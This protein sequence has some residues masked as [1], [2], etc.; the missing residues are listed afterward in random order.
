MKVFKVFFK[1]GVSE[2]VEADHIGPV[3]EGVIAM[4]SAENE[5]IAFFAIAEIIGIVSEKHI[6]H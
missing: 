1:S 2:S 4:Q 6:K 5:I 3:A